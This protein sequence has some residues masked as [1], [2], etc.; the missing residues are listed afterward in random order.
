MEDRHRRLLEADESMLAPPEFRKR[1]NSQAQHPGGEGSRRQLRAPRE[2]LGPAR[3]AVPAS[4]FF[5]STPGPLPGYSPVRPSALLLYL[6]WQLSRAPWNDPKHLATGSCRCA[7]NPHPQAGE[8]PRP[9]IRKETSVPGR[10]WGGSVGV[11]P[12]L[13][14]PGTNFLPTAGTPSSRVTGGSLEREREG[15]ARKGNWEG[16]RSSW[17]LRPRGKRLTS[18]R[19]PLS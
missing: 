8:K 6:P 17:R 3:P 11:F 14:R 19:I 4:P 5:P 10:E 9:Q 2:D 1:K 18:R 13:P 15:R 7:G 12:L 16:R